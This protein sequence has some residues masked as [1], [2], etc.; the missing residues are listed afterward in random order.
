MINSL[1]DTNSL[2]LLLRS[3]KEGEKAKLIETGSILDLTFYE[4]G[5]AL[6]TESELIRSLTLEDL[7]SLVS[8]FSKVLLSLEM[9]ALSF[10]SFSGILEI[11]RKEKLTYYD[12][13]Y[14]YSAKKHGLTLVTDHAKLSKIAR[15]YVVTKSVHDLL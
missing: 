4:V 3:S 13:S 1:F 9:L 14:I 5:N 6:W 8:T 2:L 15:K 11:A 10:D 12:S 7:A